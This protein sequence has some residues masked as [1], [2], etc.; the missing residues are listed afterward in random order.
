MQPVG[1]YEQTNARMARY[2]QSHN[3][4]EEEDPNSPRSMNSELFQDLDVHITHLDSVS[5][6]NLGFNFQET[7]QVHHHY[8]QNKAFQDTEEVRRHY[9]QNNS[10][11]NN[12]SPRGA[13]FRTESSSAKAKLAKIITVPGAEDPNHLKYQPSTPKTGENHKGGQSIKG[14]VQGIPV[15]Q[16]TVRGVPVSPRTM[17]AVPHSHGTVQAS[18][19][20]PG[21]MRGYPKTNG[22]LTQSRRRTPSAETKTGSIAFR[23]QRPERKE[24]YVTQFD[25]E[26]DKHERHRFLPGEE[27]TGKIIFDVSNEMDIR[28]IELLIIGQTTATLV[29]PES[30]VST[31]KRDVFLS[32]RS[33]IIGSPD[34]RWTSLVTPGHYVSNF[35]LQLPEGIPTS[36]TYQDKINGFNM[37]TT[38]LV[39]ARICDDVGSSSSARSTHSMNNFVKVL[40]SRKQVFH[41]KRPFDIHSVPMAMTPV[42]H[43]ED[44][45]ITCSVF[46]VKEPANIHMS[47]DRSCF[48]AGD[49]IKIHLETENRY[50]NRI[51]KITC[52]LRQ[53]VTV[54]GVRSK[55]QFNIA[56]VEEKYPEGTITK[57]N[58]SN[59]IFYDIHLPTH[60]NFL[61]SVMPGCRLATI[62]YSLIMG[63]SFKTCG[64]KL[65]LD[66]PINLGPC[67]DP[68]RLDKTNSVPF[69]NRPLRFPYFSPHSN[70]TA[71]GDVPQVLKSPKSGPPIT[72]KF[73]YGACSSRFCCCWGDN[74]LI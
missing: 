54:K 28:F 59:I 49:D 72:S 32:K 56:N 74:T 48:L 45:P 7:E 8:I 69:F 38:Y 10:N 42:N 14:P 64:G 20:Y 9:I 17:K 4:Y 26:F 18:A 58:K 57:T 41:V 31:T 53:T 51:K 62:R 16:G 61:P 68:V 70:G 34:G 71:N 1:R 19:T 27:L 12:K 67:T 30:G 43:V 55:A 29:Q 66:I 52:V 35:R 63:V 25:I 3:S 5:Q 40:V 11:G 36:I 13:K 37:E 23:R 6:N 22:H 33:Y 50:A 65:V 73:S 15:P 44:V 60:T 46:S 39:K 24:Y 2:R 21:S 47:L